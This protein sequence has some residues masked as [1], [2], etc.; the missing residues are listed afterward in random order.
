MF[1]TFK[2]SDN[3]IKKYFSSARQDFKIAGDSSVPEVIFKFC[4]DSLLKIAIAMCAKNG[5]RV[6]SRAG[7]HAELLEKLTEFLGDQDIF[8][9]GNEMRKKRNFDLYAGGILISKKEALEYR[10]WLRGIFI[11]IEDN[12]NINLKLF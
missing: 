6:K 5:L 4:Y 9:V 7:H 3:Q 10:E 11:K 12:L 1:E 2:F 8:A